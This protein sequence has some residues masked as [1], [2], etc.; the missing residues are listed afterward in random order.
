MDANTC[1]SAGNLHTRWL[2]DKQFSRERTCTHS[3]TRAWTHLYFARL[4]CVFPPSQTSK[5][6]YHFTS[7]K[8]QY[9]N[10]RCSAVSFSNTPPLTTCGIGWRNGAFKQTGINTQQIPPTANKICMAEDEHFLK[11][12]LSELITCNK[13]TVAV[14]VFHRCVCVC[15]SSYCILSNVLF[16]CAASE[17]SHNSTAWCQMHENLLLDKKKKEKLLALFTF[18][19]THTHT[20]F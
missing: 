5:G 11:R 18:F 17:P 13:K 6:E 10:P 20:I 4:F 14:A 3:Q 15:G 16:L 12:L 9:Y 19:M 1:T 7:H 2:T 8:H